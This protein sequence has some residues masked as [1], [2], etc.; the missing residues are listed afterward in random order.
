MPW[1]EL[2]LRGNQAEHGRQKSDEPG[3]QGATDLNDGSLQRA[4]FSAQLA[5]V[6]VDPRETGV[7]PIGEIVET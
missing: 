6:L 1:P 4:D 2:K 7:N 5:N 3:A